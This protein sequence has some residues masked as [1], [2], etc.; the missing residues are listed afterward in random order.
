MNRYWSTLILG[1]AAI[2]SSLYVLPGE[3]RYWGFPVPVWGEW[4]MLVVGSI[5][6]MISL[7]CMLRGK[8]KYKPYTDQDIQQAK[9]D[10]ERMY[11]RDHGELPHYPEQEKEKT[12]EQQ[13][14]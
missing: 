11:L 1:L 6:A 10:L 14:L 3:G 13:G 12:K 5:I 4:L 7:F 8:G 2:V 9:A